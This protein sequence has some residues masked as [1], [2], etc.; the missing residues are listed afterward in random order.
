MRLV[1]VPALHP[2]GLRWSAT[3]LQAHLF[4]PRCADGP[5]V[6]HPLVL[7]VSGFVEAQGGK[8]RATRAGSRA[9]PSPGRL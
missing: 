1:S 4:A 8:E 6:S 5:S 9:G 7:D 3:R 2:L